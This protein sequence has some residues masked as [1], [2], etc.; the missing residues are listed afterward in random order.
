MAKRD[1][2]AIGGSM[3]AVTAVRQLL[4]DFPA[5]FA[6][7][8]FIATHVGAHGNNLLA[9]IFAK[10]APIPVTTAI[11]SEVV[12]KG[13]AYV[14]PADRHLLVVDGVIRLG[15]GPRENLARPAI[16]PLFRSVGAT[17]GPRAIGLVL[18]GLLN[19]GAAGLADLKRC[20]GVTVV[21]NPADAEASDMPLGAL[22]ATEVDFRAP[23][24]DLPDLLVQ[25][26]GEEI[27]EPLLI[28][29]DI[30]LEIDIALGG[31]TRAATIAQIADCVP[32]SCPSCGGVLSQIKAPSPLR[33]RCQIGHAFSSEVLASR[34]DGSVVAAL[35]IALRVIEERVTL[36]EKM[37]DDARRRGRTAAAAI[38]EGRADEGR[39]FA[40]VLR[41]ALLEL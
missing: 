36:S 7:T 24:A 4:A 9:D 17:Y 19:D 25:L 31:K 2:I 34:A 5:A 37:A 29:D 41:Q 22:A 38:S 33:F 26:A 11:D 8:I 1:V 35:R 6:P 3:G 10:R 16:D 40:Q 28:P 23:L 21:Q 20:G 39:R 32:L 13:H 18:T 27:G 15:R 12:Q 14:A 30:K